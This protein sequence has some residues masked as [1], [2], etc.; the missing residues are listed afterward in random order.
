VYRCV[1]TF[2][3]YDTWTEEN[4]LAVVGFPGCFCSGAALTYEHK[5]VCLACNSTFLGRVIGS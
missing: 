4:T 2:V 1:R 5:L 3:E